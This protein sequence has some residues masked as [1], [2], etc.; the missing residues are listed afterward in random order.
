VGIPFVVLGFVLF[1][2]ATGR[3]GRRRW[4]WKLAVT[5]LVI[6]VAGDFEST[7]TGS[8]IR[9]TRGAAFAGALY[10]YEISNPV[11]AVFEKALFENSH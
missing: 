3:F 2:A 10:F 11:R 1:A 9:G 8:S 4:G 5:I 7:L 6:H